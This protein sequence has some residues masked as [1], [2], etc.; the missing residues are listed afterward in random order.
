MREYIE[1]LIREMIDERKAK[2]LVPFCVPYADLKNKV[3][4]DI[5]TPL[6]E[7]KRDGVIDVHININK[8]LII[9]LNEDSKIHNNG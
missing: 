7:M 1:R 9:F 8:D 6:N 4:N 3:L 2:S 5:R